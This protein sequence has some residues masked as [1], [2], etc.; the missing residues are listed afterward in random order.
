M[1]FHIQA[2]SS[3]T[4]K[5]AF[6]IGGEGEVRNL[7]DPNLVHALLHE[8]IFSPRAKLPVRILA[9]PI[10]RRLARLEAREEG[11]ECFGGY[12]LEVPEETIHNLLAVLDVDASRRDF[13]AL[14]G[15][16]EPLRKEYRI[17][18]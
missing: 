10:E 13:V 1:I 8:E 18:I 15:V 7:R 6:P 12:H 5:C 2:T 11:A 3:T 14:Q 17:D 16:K 9:L 4:D